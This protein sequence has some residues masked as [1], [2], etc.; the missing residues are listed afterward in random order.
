M[1]SNTGIQLSMLLQISEGSEFFFAV[2]A[3]EWVF[4][5]LVVN[6]VVLKVFS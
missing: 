6:A 4:S 2:F 3:G 5:N 1:E